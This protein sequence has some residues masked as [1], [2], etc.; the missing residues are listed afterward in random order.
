MLPKRVVT[1]WWRAGG[2]R[3]VLEDLK[4]V[5]GDLPEHLAVEQ[6]RLKV[7]RSEAV[8][9]AEAVRRHSEL[10]PRRTAAALLTC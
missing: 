3:L 5:R 10:D 7:S 2:H 8:P 6:L 1:S 9:T 4:E